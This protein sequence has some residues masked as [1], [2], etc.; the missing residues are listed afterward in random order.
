M[1]MFASGFQPGRKNMESI[2]WSGIG[3]APDK[4]IAGKI[5]SAHAHSL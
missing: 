4:R 5:N 3:I 1:G 2:A